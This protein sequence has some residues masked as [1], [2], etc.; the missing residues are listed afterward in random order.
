MQGIDKLTLFDRLAIA[1]LSGLFGLA[2]SAFVWFVVALATNN[3]TGHW[4]AFAFA[5][6]AFAVAGFVLGSSFADVFGVWFQGIWVAVNALVF[7]PTVDLE[8]NAFRPVWVTVFLASV[9]AITVWL[10]LS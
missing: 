2:T 8:A 1:L 7:N 4:A 6:S 10:S 3:P 9:V 5:A